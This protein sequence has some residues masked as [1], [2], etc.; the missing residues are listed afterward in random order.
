MNQ[1]RLLGLRLCF[2][3]VLTRGFKKKKVAEGVLSGGVELVWVE[4]L[5]RYESRVFLAQDICSGVLTGSLVEKGGG[6]EVL[7]SET[8]QLPVIWMSSSWQDCEHT[9]GL[10]NTCL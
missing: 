7:R 8:R 9:S 6:V 1:S 3:V 4:C 10:V 2:V 5:V